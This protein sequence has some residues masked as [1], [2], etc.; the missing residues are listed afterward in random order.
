MNSNVAKSEE[1]VSVEIE[2]MDRALNL[3]SLINDKASECEVIVTD[4]KNKVDGHS[5][6]GVLSL[7]SERNLSSFSWKGRPEKSE[8][9]KVFKSNKAKI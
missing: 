3:I 5:L 2:S 7:I 1:V 4:G 9:I 6:L 8:A